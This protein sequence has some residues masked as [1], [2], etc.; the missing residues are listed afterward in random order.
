MQWRAAASLPW[1]V[2]QAV[3]YLR[4]NLHRAITLEDLIHAAETSERTL[5][6]QFRQAIGMTP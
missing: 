5:H 2:H 3:C 4:D 6:R 1:C